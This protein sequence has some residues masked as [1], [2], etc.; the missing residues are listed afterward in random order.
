MEY[1][2]N[3][4]VGN[5]KNCTAMETPLLCLE[6]EPMMTSLLKAAGQQTSF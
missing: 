5:A 1:N 3:M 4:N 2:V 6:V